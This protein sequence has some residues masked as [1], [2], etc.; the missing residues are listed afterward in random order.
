MIMQLDVVSFLFCFVFFFQFR[1]EQESQLC[2][3]EFRAKFLE[4][5]L[6]LYMEYPE[7]AQKCIL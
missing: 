2:V 4:L 3:N 5:D 7:V 1:L 6:G